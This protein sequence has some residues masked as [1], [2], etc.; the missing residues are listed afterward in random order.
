M[1]PTKTGAA[2]AVGIVLPELAGRIDGFA[3]RVPTLNVS[4]V[5]LTFAAEKA[6]SVE[7]LHEAVRLAS[8]NE[9]D[10][11]LAYTDEPLVSVDFNHNPVSATLDAGLTKVSGNLIKVC[12]WYDNEWGYSNRML[13]VTL[14]LVNAK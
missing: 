8:Q 11:V 2:L 5:D 7:E 6:T 14:A 3:M 12:A 4:V 1:I 10:G 9:L 13:D